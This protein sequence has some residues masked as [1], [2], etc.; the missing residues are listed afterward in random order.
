MNVLMAVILHL[1][2]F[3]YHGQSYV[4]IPMDE[5]LAI[6]SEA[7]KQTLPLQYTGKMGLIVKPTT[8]GCSPNDGQNVPGVVP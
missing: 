5:L 7:N 6:V 1:C 8:N 4:T 2:P 3:T